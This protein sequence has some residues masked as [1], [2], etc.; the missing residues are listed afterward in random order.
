MYGQSLE[1]LSECFSSY[2][3]TVLTC[4]I[5]SEV[6]YDKSPL[7]EENLDDYNIYNHKIE[8]I[9]IS[10]IDPLDPQIFQTKYM[11][12]ERD[13]LLIVVFRGADTTTTDD[14]DHGIKISNGKI[15]HLPGEFHSGFLEKSE[16]VPV[17]FFI[18][19]IVNEK[20]KIVF[21][22][23][24]LGAAVAGLVAI[25]VLFNKQ[26][27]GNK[28]F[29]SRILFIGFGSPVF[30]DDKFK[31]YVEIYYKNNF[32]FYFN[33]SDIV[34]NL[35]SFRHF[36]LFIYLKG[37]AK[38]K[39]YTVFDCPKFTVKLIKDHLMV[40]Y[41]KNIVKVLEKENI[42]VFKRREITVGEFKQL[43]ITIREFQ[44]RKDIDECFVDSTKVCNKYSVKLNYESSLD[45]K[46]CCKNLDNIV[47]AFIYIECFDK[48]ILKIAILKTKEGK[49]DFGNFV[50][51]ENSVL[52]KFEIPKEFIRVVSPNEEI[53]I[54]KAEIEI[55]S[56]LEKTKFDIEFSKK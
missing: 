24:S 36:G 10:E 33:E 26:I 47:K 12:C 30:A 31:K 5:A 13:G 29:S 23:H 45:L 37:D 35:S 4:A 8:K 55:I 18:E 15:K 1:E 44:R 27:F 54:S 49:I 25:R 34:P 41:R 56:T 28:K 39:L 52:I 38:V 42:K 14:H 21:T 51:K 53:Q 11:I 6:I 22:G 43:F 16:Q 32:H 20:Y 9:V 50:K 3:K 40:N 2:H 19:K 17:E 48:L 46:L 7:D